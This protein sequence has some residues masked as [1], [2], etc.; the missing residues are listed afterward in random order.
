MHR[1]L[2][3]ILLAGWVFAA[4]SGHGYQWTDA[5][6]PIDVADG[7]IDVVFA[8]GLPAA[9]WAVCVVERD[10]PEISVNSVV[11]DGP[12]ID[13]VEKVDRVRT[14]LTPGVVKIRTTADEAGIAVCLKVPAGTHVRVLHG[15]VLLATPE[16]GALIRDDRRMIGR[17]VNRCWAV[18][19]IAEFF[20]GH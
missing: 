14:E 6:L 16:V 7:K 3:L 4:D 8:G 15:D 20:R 17:G 2:A 13:R 18:P 1:V 12:F 9:H 11:L 5:P 19:A 10:R